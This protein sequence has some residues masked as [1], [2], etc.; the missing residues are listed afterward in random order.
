MG[1]EEIEK[2]K[3]LYNKLDEEKEQA[4]D[5]RDILR[6]DLDDKEDKIKTLNGIVTRQKETVQAVFAG[7]SKAIHELKSVS[8]Q[9]VEVKKKAVLYRNN[10]SEVLRKLKSL[11][12]V[13]N[14]SKQVS[15]KVAT[16]KESLAGSNGPLVDMLS[17][18]LKEEDKKV[19]KSGD[20]SIDIS[21][22]PV[23]DNKNMEDDIIIP[24]KSKHRDLYKFEELNLDKE[25]ND[26]EPDGDINIDDEDIRGDEE[27][28]D[29]E[30]DIGDDIDVT[31][32]DDDGEEDEE[33][34]D[35]EEYE[36][37][38]DDVGDQGDE[39]EIEDNNL[40][41]LRNEFEQDI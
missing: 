41:H 21:D 35:M 1:A 5:E 30:G 7:K 23:E 29:E 16:P 24:K 13:P 6:E 12:S 37:G 26:S 25:V 2:I 3:E 39:E 19:K 28:E 34:T 40:N 14:L 33:Q 18:V 4:E 27:L 20:D 9:L 31:N 36:E 11:E 15:H 17:D 32:G 8:K 22:Y 10:L 38:G